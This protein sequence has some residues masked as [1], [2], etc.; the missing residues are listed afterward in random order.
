ML[1]PGEMPPIIP[2][3]AAAGGTGRCPTDYRDRMGRQTTGLF[4]LLG[5]FRS[6]RSI[7]DATGW[8]LKE[9]KRRAVC[10]ERSGQGAGCWA[11]CSGGTMRRGSVWP[12]I[13]G[14]DRLSD[15]RRGG[16]P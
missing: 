10:V 11:G 16:G 7:N 9:Y 12:A 1:P 8:P 5:W 14:R 15:P 6:E 13:T 3:A 4:L 2:I